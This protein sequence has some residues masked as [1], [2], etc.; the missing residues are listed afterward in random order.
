MLEEQNQ[1]LINRPP[2]VVVLGHIDHGKTSL[3]DAI[4]KTQVAEKESGGITQHIGAYQVEKDGKKI[5]FLDTPGHEAFSQMRSRGAK[6]ADIA[7]LVIDCCESVQFQTKEAISHIKKE[8]LPIIIALNKIDRSEANPEK[9]KV[10]LQKEGILVEDYGGKVPAVKTSAKSGQGINELLDMILLI[11]EMENLKAD[12]SKPAEGTIIESFLD[13]QRG[14][15]AT[16]LV[17]EG[18]LKI[19]DFL[20][21][22]STLGKVK[23]LE[24]FQG[25]R[26]EKV[27]PGQPAIIIGFEKAPKVGENF[28][29]FTDLES[30]KGFIKV[31]EKKEPATQQIEEG[32]KVLNLI[33]KTDV[34]GSI[35]AIEDVLKNIPQDKIALRILK[36]DAGDINENDVQLAKCSKALILGFRIKTTSLAK[37]LAEKE[38]VRII[39]FE[40]IYELVE[41]IRKYMGRIMESEVVRTDLGKMKVLVKFWA[42]KNRQI[43]G[44]RMI[45]GT[46]KKGVSIEVSRQEEI[47]G[48]GRMI[49]LQ[50]NK[51]D[52]EKAAKG[53]EI[54]ILYEGEGKIEEGDILTFFL[55]ERKKMEL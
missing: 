5:T 16:L 12:I 43:I 53:E 41:G 39:T 52:I 24:D 14:P 7:I 36:A 23:N 37:N 25:K 42:E 19:G 9:V 13:S 15:T 38:K 6:V 1:N 2:V 3:L 50:K 21:T 4:R 47:I 30:A 31:E 17:N 33:L 20:A 35:E 11:A 48:C 22:L 8:G 26:I 28:R 32:K 54:G 18:I 40:L 34:L 49:N 44:G 10:G 45:E 55:E 46:V 27:L 51:K 29:I